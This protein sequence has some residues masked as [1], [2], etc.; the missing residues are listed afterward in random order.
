[1]AYWGPLMPVVVDEYTLLRIAKA[2]HEA[3]VAHGDE[4]EV[5]LRIAGIWD[6]QKYSFP[7]L[8]KHRDLRIRLIEFLEAKQA[9][10][11]REM[12]KTDDPEQIS[13]ENERFERLWERF[14]FLRKMAANDCHTLAVVKHG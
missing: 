13:E 11:V 12:S 8:T 2:I 9:K 14:S 1:V 4:N 7:S 3:D 10:M 6:P 5:W